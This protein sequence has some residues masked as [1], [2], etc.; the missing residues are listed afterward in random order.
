MARCRAASPL[1]A[2]P[3][4]VLLRLEWIESIED[5]KIDEL[6]K[7]NIFPNSVNSV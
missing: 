3:A 4:E 6:L 1:Y 7:H 2:V 5:Y